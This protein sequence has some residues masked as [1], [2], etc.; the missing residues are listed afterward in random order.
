MIKDL[1]TVNPTETDLD[2]VQQRES[3]AL[4]ECWKSPEHAEAV[5]AFIEKRPPHFPPRT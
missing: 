4:R 3:E 1:F 2:L 5:T